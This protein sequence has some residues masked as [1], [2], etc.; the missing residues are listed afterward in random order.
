MLENGVWRTVAGRRIF[1]KNG[2]SLTDAMKNSGK[3][4]KDS[5]QKK[6]KKQFKEKN[7]FES[8]ESFKEYIKREFKDCEKNIEK[9]YLS[10]ENKL[11]QW[12]VYI[13][14]KETFSPTTKRFYNYETYIPYENVYKQDR[15]IL[16]FTIDNIKEEMKN[17][18]KK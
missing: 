18:Y 16:K 6:I 5:L 11:G 15:S 10:K 17:F 3:F 9:I 14:G 2:Q 12:G 7:I 13:K 4:Q 1:I 8:K